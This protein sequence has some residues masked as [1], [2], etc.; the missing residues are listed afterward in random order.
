V[1]DYKPF[2][3]V[4]V[5]V[6]EVHALMPGNEVGYKGDGDSSEECGGEGMELMLIGVDEA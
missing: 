5:I 2:V 3:T 4:R 6:G 1:S